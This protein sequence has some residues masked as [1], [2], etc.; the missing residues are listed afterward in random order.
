MSSANSSLPPIEKVRSLFEYNPNTGVI[1]KVEAK[2]RP[3]GTRVVCGK[4]VL[5]HHLA[6]L[7]YFGRWPE[8]DIDHIN[9]DPTDNRIENLREVDHAINMQNRRAAQ[10][11]NLSS[12]VLGVTKRGEG[13]YFARIWIGGKNGTNVHLGVFATAEEAHQAY[14]DA[15]RKMHAGC[16]I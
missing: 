8:K 15:K 11:N 2:R 9:G 6:W 16:T 1:R 5:E 7:L 12:G 10:K 3:Y 13:R 14:L 4:R